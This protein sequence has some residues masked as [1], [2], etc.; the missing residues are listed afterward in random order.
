MRLASNSDSNR[1]KM[2]CT[3]DALV[4]PLIFILWETV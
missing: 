2:T 1:L 4:Q 3:T